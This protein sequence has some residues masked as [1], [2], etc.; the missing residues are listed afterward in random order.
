MVSVFGGV[1]TGLRMLLFALGVG[2]GH[3]TGMGHDSD[4]SPIT[5]VSLAS[6]GIFTLFFGLGGLFFM[7]E[8]CLPLHFS[9]ILAMLLG[10][11]VTY[12]MGM[13]MKFM[14]KLQS[15]GSNLVVDKF[16]GTQGTAYTRLGP[17]GM[18]VATLIIDGV[19][20]ERSVR[21]ESDQVIHMNEAVKVSKVQSGQVY[22]VPVK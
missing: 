20:R 18:G 16:V 4:S 5:G 2:H 1:I 15:P 13:L 6:L 12:L 14:M 9:V 17:D 10:A 21:N 7:T 11:G 8:V 19:S 3:D 22:V